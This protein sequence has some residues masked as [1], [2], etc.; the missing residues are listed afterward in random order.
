MAQPPRVVAG[1][2]GTTMSSGLSDAVCCLATTVDRAVTGA[3]TVSS[4]L[5]A[6]EA[7][8]G[9]SDWICGPSEAVRTD[10]VVAGSGGV[11]SAAEGAGSA[12]AVVL[13]GTSLTVK[14]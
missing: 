12:G 1:R 2:D 11:A 5:D 9:A 3:M 8:V 7:S 6:A 14:V 10:L 4:V 13:D